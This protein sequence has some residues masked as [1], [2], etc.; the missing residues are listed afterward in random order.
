MKPT[1]AIDTQILTVSKWWTSSSHERS[2]DGTLTGQM[3]AS[4][5]HWSGTS[6]KYL[7]YQSFSGCPIFRGTLGRRVSLLRVEEPSVVFHV[8]AWTREEG[9]Y[10]SSA[11]ALSFSLETFAV[12]GGSF[13]LLWGEQPGD[14][15]PTIIPGSY[16]LNKGPCFLV[17]AAKNGFMF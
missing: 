2:W 1:Y 12:K 15:D 4:L 3:S 5:F 8:E 11:V 9:F 16:G 7:P 17:Y 10:I 14:Q 6:Q 13:E